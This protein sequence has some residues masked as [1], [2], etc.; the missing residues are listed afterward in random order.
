MHKLGYVASACACALFVQSAC[1]QTS[2]PTAADVQRNIDQNRQIS[3]PAVPKPMAKK[4]L[5][6][7]TTDQGFARLSAVQV[8]SPLFQDDLMAYWM[9]EINKPVPAQKLN[10]FKAFAWELFQKKGYLAY[11]NTSAQPTPEGSVLTVTVAFPSV[12]KVSVVTVDG[13]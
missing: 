7:A 3:N 13:D 4:P 9:S 1:A 10:D 5:P 6:P 2:A 8:N 11:I 12:G